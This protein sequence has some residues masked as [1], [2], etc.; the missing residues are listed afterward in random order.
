MSRILLAILVTLAAS[1]PAWGEDF[2]GPVLLTAPE[3]EACEQ[4]KDDL[5]VCRTG[6]AKIELE[7]SRR[8]ITEQEK[9]AAYYQAWQEAEKRKAPVI[10]K[11]ESHWPYLLG[12]SA[13]TALV[14]TVVILLAQ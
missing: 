14:F 11:Q 8:L 13:A 12:G 3:Y 6:S 1:E 5:R 9:A 7:L 4:A 2:V 10:Q